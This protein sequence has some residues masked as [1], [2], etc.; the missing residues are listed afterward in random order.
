M[1]KNK[2]QMKRPE[3]QMGALLW[4]GENRGGAPRQRPWAPQSAER[5][6]QSSPPFKMENYV[7]SFKA[8]K[9]SKPKNKKRYVLVY[10]KGRYLIKDLDLKKK[11]HQQRYWQIFWYFLI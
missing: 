8:R 2:R 6:A 11:G 9:K 5:G 7:I 3:A 10:E 1:A 4:G